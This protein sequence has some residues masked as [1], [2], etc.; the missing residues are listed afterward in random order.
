MKIVGIVAEYNPFHRGH[1][2][3]IREARRL[4]GEE[5]TI[6]AVMSGDFVQR[7]EPAVYQKHARA[8]A[9]CR[10]GVDL[11]VEL[12]LR[13]CLSPAEGF[14]EGA[15]RLLKALGAE[16]LSF[17]S[18]TADAE[19][20]RET[21]ALLTGPGFPE[22]VREELKHCPAQGSA[23]A[24]QKTAERMLGRPIPELGR[25]NDILALEYLKTIRRDG[26]AMEI[27]PVPRRGSGHD[28]TE[29]GAF[30]SAMFLREKLRNGENLSD[31]V[32]PEAEAVFWREREAGREASDTE[33]RDRLIL[34]RLRFLDQADFAMLPDTG[35]GIENR[36]YR[37]VREEADYEAVLSAVTGK[38]C[39]R[40]RVR[41]LC[42]NAVLGVKAAED[43]S[44]PLYARV[45]AFGPEGRKWLHE[46]GDRTEIPLLIKPAQVRRLNDAAQEEFELGARAHDFFTLCYPKG[47]VCPVGEDWR[48][49]PVF[50]EPESWRESETK[51]A[52]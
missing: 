42:M 6:I 4:A 2:W 10:C 41:R 30:P 50:S 34:S 5:C 21:A 32:P 7:G 26:M 24:G 38:R 49:G 3:Q 8:E 25:P 46:N 9:V 12:P 47:A 48:T 20:L 39:P 29:G 43:R 19:S 13:F 23:E 31:L 16:T 45:L 33:I 1:A 51:D 27:L 36:L 35:D 28:R 44:S 15:V 14:A 52:E 18:E 40:A 37:A 11:V 17:G 22:L